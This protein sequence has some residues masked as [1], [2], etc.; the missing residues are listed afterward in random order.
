MSSKLFQKELGSYVSFALKVR[1]DITFSGYY[2]DKGR[3]TKEP[4]KQDLPSSD[5][6]SCK[7]LDSIEELVARYQMLK[8]YLPPK[9]ALSKLKIIPGHIEL[10]DEPAPGVKYKKVSVNAN[11]FEIA[12]SVAIMVEGIHSSYLKGDHRKAKASYLDFQNYLSL[13]RADL[14]GEFRTAG[15]LE[16]TMGMYGIGLNGGVGSRDKMY[17]L[18]VFIVIEIWVG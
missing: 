11:Q 13:K 4:L 12:K 14:I 1:P 3:Y 5:K 16:D 10:D 8:K 7:E 18:P 6:L 2:N 17:W 9:S 15:E